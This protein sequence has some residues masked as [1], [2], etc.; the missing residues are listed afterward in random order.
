MGIAHLHTRQR[1]GGGFY[2]YPQLSGGISPSLTH[3][4]MTGGRD[5]TLFATIRREKGA[6]RSFP[7][8]SLGFFPC[9][10]F[11]KERLRRELRK[12]A[13]V[14]APGAG[15][16]S[17]SARRACHARQR[18]KPHIKK[19]KVGGLS[20]VGEVCRSDASLWA[21]GSRPL[22]SGASPLWAALR[23]IHPRIFVKRG[24]VLFATSGGSWC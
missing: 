6:V 1:L 4:P 10:A 19:E 3:Y 17:P 11:A 23:P 15:G 13:L 18:R 8:F 7:R 2:S 20:V 21:G 24:R 16:G 12:C 9:F 5:K 22:P 14:R